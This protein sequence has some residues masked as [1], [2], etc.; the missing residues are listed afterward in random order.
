MRVISQDGN[1]DIP[2]EQMVITI[3]G[4]NIIAYGANEIHHDDYIPMASYSTEEKAQKAMEMLRNVYECACYCN[5]AFDSAAQVQRPYLF[6]NNRVFQFP[7]D[8]E[9]EV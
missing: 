2:Y 3:T 1:F 7:Q 6:M 9:V 4:K 5:D 8:S